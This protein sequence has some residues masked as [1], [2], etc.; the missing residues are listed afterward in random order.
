MAMSSSRSWSLTARAGAAVAIPLLVGALGVPFAT[1]ASAATGD[2]LVSDD[3]VTFTPDSTLSLFTSMG[4]MVPGDRSTEHVWVRNGSDADA[5]LRVDLIDPTTDDDA[6]A[7]AFSLSVVT[8]D[9]P[10]SAP[11]T[12]QT[13]LDNG[14]C[15]VLDDGIAVGAGH[16]VRI[17]LTA[18]VDPALDGQRGMLGAVG[19]RLRALLIETA[20]AGHERP[21]SACPE[22][23]VRPPAPGGGDLATT[24]PGPLLPLWLFAGS[25]TM[26]GAVLYAV[27]RRRCAAIDKFTEGDDGN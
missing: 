21:G 16:T 23:P 2:L 20:A 13:G 14:N 18:A 9:A 6:L 10:A 25:A 24:G 27:A 22:L 7:D 8:R 4:R 5:V 1:P 26:A 19:F 11:V 3:G 17:D 12:I 15:T